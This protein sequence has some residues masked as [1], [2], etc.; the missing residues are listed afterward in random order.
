MSTLCDRAQNL[1]W[2]IAARQHGDFF[3]SRG[4]V[5]HLFQGSRAPAD[6][7]VTAVVSDSLTR[8][9]VPDR[10]VL[11]L[12]KSMCT[13]WIAQ[14]ATN[15]VQGLD[16]FEVH[17]S[18]GTSQAFDHFYLRHRHRRFRML[19]GEYFY[20]VR[21]WQAHNLDWSWIADQDPLAPNDAL[22]ISVPFCDT[23]SVHAAWPGILDICNELGI[24]VLV[25][26]CY[27]SISHSVV[28]DV[29]HPC[30][31]TVTFSMSKAFPVADLRI[32]MRYVRPGTVDGQQIYDRINYNNSVSARVGIDIMQNFRSDHT[33]QVHWDRYREI[34]QQL[35]LEPG[36]SVIFAVGDQSWQQYNRSL[37][38]QQFDLDLDP[39]LFVNRICVT[40][41]LDNWDIFQRVAYEN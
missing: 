18:A 24:P 5:A 10:Q 26:C 1:A 25:D 4:A 2:T 22:V 35:G 13:S 34:C 19:I 31:D 9:R 40:S 32:G 15:S 23:G 28:L 30:V 14:H 3:G 38:L 41:I 36:Q 6:D 11:P 21:A 16:Q 7:D 8:T 37:L 33:V 12:F 17:F 20:H 29:N 27:W 39:D